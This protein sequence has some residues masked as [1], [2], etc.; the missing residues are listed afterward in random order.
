MAAVLGPSYGDS[1]LH[2]STSNFVVMIES[3]AVASSGPSVIRS[4]IGEVISD[5]ELGGPEAALGIGNAHLVVDSEQGAFD[6]IAA[7]LSY[8]PPNSTLPAP[9]ASSRPPRLDPAAVGGRVPTNPKSAYDMYD[10]IESI[11]DES[12]LFRG[13]RA[14]AGPDHSAGSDRRS[15]HRSDRQSADGERRCARSGGAPQVGAFRG[16]V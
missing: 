5:T 7:F 14:R 3:A 10:V 16:H 9:R 11:V 12:R 1:A 4:A 6:A 13:P 15:R 8:L 2:A